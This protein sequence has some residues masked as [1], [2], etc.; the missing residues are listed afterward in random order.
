MSRSLVG[1][2]MTRTLDGPGEQLRQQEPA[3]LAAGEVLHQAP[4]SLGREEE[5]LEIAQDVA[6]LAV[7]RDGV[8]RR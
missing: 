3:P 6:V 2:S 5:I 7:D 1:S 4:R 8:V